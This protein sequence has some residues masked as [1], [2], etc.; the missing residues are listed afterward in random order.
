MFTQGYLYELNYLFAGMGLLAAAVVLTLKQRQLRLHLGHFLLGGLVLLYWLSLLVAVDKEKAVLEAVRMTAMLPFA[1]I[2]T[3]LSKDQM[4]RIFRWFP[5]AGAVVAGVGIAGGL[6]RQGRLESTIGYANALAVCL[7]VCLLMTLLFYVSEGR[8]R[9]F[10]C[11]IIQ[12]AGLLLTLSRSVWVLWALSLG[13]LLFIKEFRSKGLLLKI[14][15]A[16]LTGYL[17]AAIVKGNFLFFWSRLQTIQPTTSEFRLRLVYWKDALAML[18]D[19]LWL[20]AGGGGWSVLQAYYQSEPYYVRFVHNH[21]LQLAVDVGLPGAL[22]FGGIVLLFYVKSSRWLLSTKPTASA[23]A[24]FWPKGLMLIG[25]VMLLHAGFDFDFS[26][27]LVIALLWLLIERVMAETPVEKIWPVKFKAIATSLLSAGLVVLLACTGW[28][29]V[30]KAMQT[31]A[32]NEAAAGELETALH[33][34]AKAQKMMP[35]AASTYYDMAKIYVQLG[36]QTKDPSQYQSALIQIEQAVSR[37]P[38]EE[39]YRTLEIELR[40][41]FKM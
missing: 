27:V 22:L 21:Y 26:F 23:W 10:V 39:L 2:S 18:I 4:Q 3:T 14:G 31:K 37:V 16:H 12:S 28:L 11:M 30:G 7:L 41:S 6:Y 25:T 35:W 17:L 1:L 36:N 24:D 8:K 19:H 38:Q 5:Y 32:Q 33:H 29:A 20:G 9:D 15:A 13:C 34:T 40:K